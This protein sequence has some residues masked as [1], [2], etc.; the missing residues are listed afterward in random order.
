[1]KQQKKVGIIS[2]HASVNCGSFL[3]NWS[4][5]QTIKSLG[6]SAETIDFSNASQQYM[7]STLDLR[8]KKGKKSFNGHL[9]RVLGTMLTLPYASR[10]RQY[11]KDYRKFSLDNLN[12]S[13]RYTELSQLNEDELG[14]DYYVAGSDQIWSCGPDHDLAYYFP[15]VKKHPK[16]SYAP[17]LGGKNPTKNFW[18]KE[19]IDCVKDFS[20]LSARETSGC[21]YIHKVTGKKVTETLDPTLLLDKETFSKIERPTG[22]KGKYIFFYSIGYE[23]LEA[24]KLAKQIRKKTN[25]PVVVWN[26]QEYLLDKILV[27][28]CTQTKTQNPGVWLSLVKNAEFVLTTSFHGAALSTV[29]GKNFYMLKKPDHRQKTLLE[30]GIPKT[31]FIETIEEFSLEPIDYVKF[32]SNLKKSRAKSI[33]YLEAA[34]KGNQ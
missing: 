13:K 1:M 20:N 29:Y 31:H 16:I 28:D 7:H 10:F 6:Y 23:Y 14:Y 18:S 33:N 12:L 21:E 17:S 8:G 11:N 26:P 32:Q 19:I 3:Q 34:L 15:F 22:I 2:F 5:Q 4:L 24:K 9:K 30:L 27:G 25:L